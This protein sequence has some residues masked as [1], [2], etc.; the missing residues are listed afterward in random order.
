MLITIKH[1]LDVQDLREQDIEWR[2]SLQRTGERLVRCLR[3]RDRLYRQQ[4][5]LCAAFTVL[6]RHISTYATY[7]HKM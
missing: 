5:K 6:L 4:K 2:N 7:I 1:L 3:M